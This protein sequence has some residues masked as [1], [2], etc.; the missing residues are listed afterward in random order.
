MA[1]L[2]AKC[3]AP[4]PQRESI[5]APRVERGCIGCC[6][7]DRTIG[8]DRLYTPVNVPT[9]RAVKQQLPPPSAVAGS[10]AN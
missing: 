7:F 9:Q 3:G 1:V 8:R 2:C 6:A 10:R 4:C 5:F